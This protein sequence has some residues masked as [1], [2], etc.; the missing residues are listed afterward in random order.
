MKLDAAAATKQAQNMGACHVI[1]GCPPISLTGMT[2]VGGQASHSRCAF[3]YYAV[4]SCS[5]FPKKKRQD[6]RIKKGRE[7]P[8]KSKQ[9]H[10]DM[11]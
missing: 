4:A 6:V 9:R 7:G 2:R 10:V 8:K 5:V 11:W 3:I 1:L